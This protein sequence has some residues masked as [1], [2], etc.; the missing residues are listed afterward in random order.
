MTRRKVALVVSDVDGTLLTSDKVLTPRNRAAVLS[1]ADRGIPFTIISS[2]PPFGLNMLIEP[3]NLRLPIAAFNGGVITMPDRRI[4]ERQPLGA[5]T[6]GKALAYLEGRGIEVWLF[7]DLHWHARDPNGA[8]VN[9]EQRTVATPPV[10]VESFAPLLETA[11]KLVGVS[12]DSERLAQCM[13]ETKALLGG[14]ATVSRSQRY[15]L[16]VN[17]PQ[18]NKGAALEILARRCKVDL[19][20]V[21]T[22]GDMDNDVPMFQRSGFSIAMGNG[23]AAARE[24]ASTT[25][26]SND[27]DGFAEAIERHVLSLPSVR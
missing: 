3:L 24:A 23:S 6:A 20:E 19:A 1:L 4:V 13:M 21:V 22:L 11:I 26:S 2:R 18:V 12:E 7:S 8:Y 27:A 17:A 9:L 25:A 14:A 16:D 15:Y 5:E 10:I